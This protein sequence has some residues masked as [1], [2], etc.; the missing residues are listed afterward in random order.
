MHVNSTLAKLVVKEEKKGNPDSIHQTVQTCRHKIN[1]TLGTQPWN[2][3]MYQLYMPF[4]IPYLYFLS[5]TQS[6]KIPRISAA[7]QSRAAPISARLSQDGGDSCEKKPP[8][9]SSTGPPT[10]IFQSPAP[11]QRIKRAILV[12]FNVSS[13]KKQA[14]SKL[15]E[16]DRELIKS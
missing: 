10:C 13:G 3:D 14:I 11:P 15:T 7:G 2:W 4:A 9:F 8:I 1:R 5:Y 6:T 12:A 16:R